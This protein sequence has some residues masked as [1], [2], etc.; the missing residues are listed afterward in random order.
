VLVYLVLRYTTGMTLLKIVAQ[1]LAYF[2][3]HKAVTLT[4][5]H[6]IF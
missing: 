2:A 4:K 5:V 1:S 6:T 3:F